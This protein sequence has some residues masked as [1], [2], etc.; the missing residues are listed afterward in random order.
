MI[1]EKRLKEITAEVN[2]IFSNPGP[3]G[4]THYS[5]RL[6]QKIVNYVRFKKMKERGYKFTDD[7]TW[8]ADTARYIF[9]MSDA[10]FMEALQS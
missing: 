3:D 9:A 10:E 4:H 8:K 5:Q 6:G 7:K 2:K 1:D